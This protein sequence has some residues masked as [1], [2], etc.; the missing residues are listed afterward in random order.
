MK[1][2]NAIAIT[3]WYI[4]LGGLWIIGSDYIVDSLTS[5]PYIQT[6]KG[7]MFIAV[8][9]LLIF[10]LVRRIERIHRAGE[11]SEQRFRT[12][13]EAAP[14]GIL[15]QVEGK[16]AYVN[17]TCVDLM[18]ADSAD[19]LLGTDILDRLHPED[20][21]EGLERMNALA[22]GM[23]AQQA[24]QLIA[25][26][27]GTTVPVESVAVPFHYQGKNGGL[28]FIRDISRRKEVA[29]E[30]EKLL[31]AIEQTADSVLVTDT[32]GVIEYVNPAFVESSGYSAAELIGKTPRIQQSGRHGETFYRDIWQTITSGKTWRG[33]IVNKRKD[34]DLYTEDVTI[35]PLFEDGAIV[36]YVAVKRDITHELSLEQQLAQAQKMETV[37]RLAGGVAH[38]FNN[39]LSVILGYSE[40]ALAKLPHNDAVRNDLAEI[41]TA[42]QRSAELT[43]QLLAFARRQI[44]DPKVIDLNDSI[45]TALKMLQRLIGEHIALK[46]QP[47]PD[48]WPIRL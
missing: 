4:V 8:T 25:R 45:G 6:F 22:Q 9:A 32:D 37:G 48:L 33:H 1:P 26:M 7:L 36:N 18:G 27:D 30:R 24:E 2:N 40:L 42:A 21:A 39:M 20:H 35:S 31:K 23:P 47:A 13:V 10:S 16:F 38:D 41:S 28:G 5:A 12:L 34:G 43:R 29:R 44:I 14:E 19:D 17:A 15:I 46:W 11:E 3:A